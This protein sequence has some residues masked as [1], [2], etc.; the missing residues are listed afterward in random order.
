MTYDELLKARR[1]HQEKVSVEEVEHAIR[2]AERDLKSA[3][4]MMAEDRDW[5]FAIAYD[6]V[7][8]ASRAFM[9]AQ[10]FRTA[11]NESDKKR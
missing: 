10:G 8:Q 7:L 1:I 3:R 5:G 9:F 4:V 6:A 2:R 11:S